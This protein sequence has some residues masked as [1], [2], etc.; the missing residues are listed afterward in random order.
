MARVSE[1]PGK[2]M[3]EAKVRPFAV[4]YYCERRDP[5]FDRKAHDVLV[6][7]RQ[8]RMCAGA[9]GDLVAEPTDGAGA[10]G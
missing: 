7:C 10:R 3:D 8:L 6:A 5:D 2:I 1:T 9:D 4:T